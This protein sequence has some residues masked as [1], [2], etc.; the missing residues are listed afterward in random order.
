M[1]HKFVTEEPTLTTC[2]TVN[3]TPCNYHVFRA[4]AKS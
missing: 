1:A 2:S 4:K 3:K